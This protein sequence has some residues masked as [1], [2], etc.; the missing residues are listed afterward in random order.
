MYS[1]V[2]IRWSSG[3]SASFFLI[4]LVLPTHCLSFLG[5]VACCRMWGTL[6]RSSHQTAW[7]SELFSKKT[8]NAEQL[9]ARASQGFHQE[10]ECG[11][12]KL[13]NVGEQLTDFFSSY[14]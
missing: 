2:H 3:L 8:S 6:P 12:L 10:K 14:M 5:G 13:E 1:S 4:S 11:V 7:S 9:C